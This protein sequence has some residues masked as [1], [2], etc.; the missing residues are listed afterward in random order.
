MIELPVVVAIIAV[1]A[2]MLLPALT[3]AKERARTSAWL[4]RLITAARSLL[5]SIYTDP[6]GQL[7]EPA[8][9]H[10]GRRG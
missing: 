6:T 1:L 5:I 10:H 7:N 8:I 4:R 2:A 3:K 9:G